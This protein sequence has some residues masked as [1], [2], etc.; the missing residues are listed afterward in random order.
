MR[1]LSSPNDGETKLLDK[2]IE[3]VSQALLNQEFRAV[4]EFGSFVTFEREGDPLKIH[5]G[6]VDHLPHLMERTNSSQ[7]EKI[8]TICTASLSRR[9]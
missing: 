6:P 4:D 2:G 3:V 9:P 8:P 5:V 7:K 1:V